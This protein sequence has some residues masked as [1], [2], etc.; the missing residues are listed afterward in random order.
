[1]TNRAIWAPT[2][3][4]DVKGDISC[5]FVLV[6]NLNSE[7][8]ETFEYSCKNAG[9]FINHAST[10]DHEKTQMVRAW[11]RFMRICKTWSPYFI[12]FERDI[13]TPFYLGS[14]Q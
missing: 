11:K 9:Y 13:Y 2:S 14:S 4:V 7:N 12:L 10:N 5:R 6:R 8:S 3:M 1:M